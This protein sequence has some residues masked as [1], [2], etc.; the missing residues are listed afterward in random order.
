MQLLIESNE[1]TIASWLARLSIPAADDIS[2][3]GSDGGT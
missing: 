2:K 1:N 3:A